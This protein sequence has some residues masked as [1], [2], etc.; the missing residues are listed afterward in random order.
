MIATRRRKPRR[1]PVPV[2]DPAYRAWI[3]RLP[4]WICYMEVYAWLDLSDIIVF[5]TSIWRRQ[6]SPTEVAHVGVRGRG[7]KCA[8]RETMPLC[9][10]HHQTGKDAHHGPLGR[11]FFAHHGLSREVIIKRLNEAYERGVE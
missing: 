7:Q 4:C 3:K 2:D 8:D 11:G 10:A 9:R 5:C 6:K 1:R